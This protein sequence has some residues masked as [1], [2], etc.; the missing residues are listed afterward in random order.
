MWNLKLLKSAKKWSP[1]AGVFCGSTVISCHLGS[2]LQ[3]GVPRF[4][5]PGS[6]LVMRQQEAHRSDHIPGQNRQFSKGIQPTN[7][8]FDHL[9]NT[10]DWTNKNRNTNSMEWFDVILETIVSLVSFEAWSILSGTGSNLLDLKIIVSPKK[11]E[12]S[13]IC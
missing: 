3:I 12:S 2:E 11:T 7:R 13:W 1:V 10:G 9:K 4:N 5:R 6:H 8:T